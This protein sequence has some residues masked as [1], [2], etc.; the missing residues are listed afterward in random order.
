[1]RAKQLVPILA[2]KFGVPYETAEVID[3]ALADHGLRAKGKGRS[4]PE[5]TRREAIHFL[6]GCMIVT[7]LKGSATTRAAADVEKWLSAF[8]VVNVV[9]DDRDIFAAHG[10]DPDD[11]NVTLT[12]RSERLAF[13][14]GVEGCGITL[15]DYLL[16]MMH[17]D[18]LMLWS[19]DRV[20]FSISPTHLKAT[21]FFYEGMGDDLRVF[22]HEEFYAPGAEEVDPFQ[23]TIRADIS[24]SGRFLHEIKMRTEDPLGKVAD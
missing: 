8:T 13:L 12:D 18:D 23:E 16:L 22:D 19:A 1:M 15:V 24:V 5:M 21:V 14:K 3:R 20:R 17:D 4:W 9:V 11:D 2:E 7:T 6:I 10:I